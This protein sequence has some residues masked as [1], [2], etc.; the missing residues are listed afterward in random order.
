MDG[1]LNQDKRHPS[2]IS[3]GW[4]IGKKIFL[5]SG[6]GIAVIVVVGLISFFSMNKINTL[7]NKITDVSLVEWSLANTIENDGRQIGVDL[8]RY[9]YNNDKK[10]WEAVKKG[11]VHL[12]GDIDTTHSLA[13]KYDLIRV[14]QNVSDL[15]NNLSIFEESIQGFY[16]A[17]ESLANYKEQTRQS[18][19][20]FAASLEDYYAV[21][22]LELSALSGQARAQK[23]ERIQAIRDFELQQTELLTR[24]WQKEAL[25]QFNDYQGIEN[26][27]VSSRATFGEFL[28]TETSMDGE[29][30]LNIALA[31]L[32]D[33]VETVRAMIAARNEVTKLDAARNNAFNGIIETAD[34]LAN[35]AKEDA[36]T[37]A[38][39]TNSV[40]SR[41]KWVIGSVSALSAMLAFAFGGFVGRSINKVL[42]EIIAQ[43]TTG[44]NEVQASSEQLSSSSQ[45]LASSASKQAASLEETSSS[46]EEMGSQIKQTDENSTEAEIAMEEAKP[47]VDRGVDAMVRMNTA[48]EEIKNSSDETSKIIKTIDDIAFQTNLLALNAAVEAARAGEAGKGFA[49]VAEEVR[50][51]AQRSAEA[52]KD[53]SILIQKSQESSSRGTLVADEV[54]ENLQ[55]IAQSINS[56]ST[57]VVEISA[58]SKEQADGIQ[59]M[60]VVMSDMDT[61][62]QGN[63]SASEESAGA[64][65]ELTAQAEELNQIVHRL[66]NLVG[67][68][69][70]E[71][72]FKPRSY[73][74]EQER[75]VY[76]PSVASRPVVDRSPAPARKVEKV[77]A[78]KLEND[79]GNK[80]A[81]ELIP[82]GDD[83]FSEF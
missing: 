32:N 46:L 47:L 57:L 75:E 81:H 17:N 62:V 73:E 79:N 28:S 48:M 45:Q 65:E 4:T 36:Y 15:Q 42:K 72:S 11:L 19:E 58:A 16:T 9:A 40:V 5:L 2:T 43:L 50:N 49:V 35:I 83:D 71:H 37:E 25:G 52:A 55:K 64:A 76:K 27:L 78:P 68:V 66:A 29:I 63:A 59:Q 22:D 77:N 18:G 38:K 13:M 24:L 7:T 23:L 54:S 12:K 3:S 26:Q 82:L 31:T 1:L 53:T 60:N 61:V 74:Y 14:Q 67:G 69:N 56:V 34:N 20:D 6:G 44:A 80:E 30:F 39:L 33:N 10:A 70:E 21:V 51:L 8:M 41:A